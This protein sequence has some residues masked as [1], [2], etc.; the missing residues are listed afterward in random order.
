LEGKL[1]P[2]CRKRNPFF[3]AGASTSFLL[4]IKKGGKT[5]TIC[6]GGAGEF[7]GGKEGGGEST[8]NGGRGWE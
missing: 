4:W 2:I 7:C 6:R 3:V 5:L 8:L 1:F